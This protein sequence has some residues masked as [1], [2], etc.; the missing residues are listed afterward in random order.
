[1]SSELIWKQKNMNIT[2]IIKCKFPFKDS[3]TIKYNHC[4]HLKS[5]NA[6]VHTWQTL[7]VEL[8]IYRPPIVAKL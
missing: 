3:K 7:T 1:M 5:E 8:T 6:L 2:R 4:I